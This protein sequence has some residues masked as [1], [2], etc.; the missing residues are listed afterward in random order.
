MKVLLVY[1]N[2]QMVALLPSNIAILAASLKKAGVD[3]RLFDTTLYRIAEKSVDDVRVEHMQ[4]RPFNLKE[5]GVDYKHTDVFEDFERT[6]TEFS[7]DI[8]GISTGDDTFD[9]G[10][11]LVSKV[12][13]PDIHVILGGVYPT[14]SPEEAICNEYV[15]SI[16]IG[17]GEHALVELCLKMQKK[18][19]ITRIRNLWVKHNDVIYK[20]GVRE[21]ADINKLPYE[22]FDVFEEKRFFRPMQGKIFKMI[23]VTIDRGCPYNCSFCAAPL[24]RKLYSDAGQSG[25]FRIKTTAR[26][27]EELQYHVGRYKA[28]YIYFN[29][30]TFFARKEEDIEKFAREYAS[31]IGLPFWCQTRIETITERRIKLLQDMNCDR[32]SIGIEHGNEEFRKTVLNKHFT[33]QQVIRAFKL[34]EKS[35]IPV[36]VNNIIGFPDETRELAF[37]TIRLNRSIKADSVNAYFFVPYRGTSLR[38][39]CIEK[40]YIHADAKTDSLMRRSILN[41]PQFHPNEIEGLVR[42]FPLYVKMPESYFDKIRIAEQL[43]E[44]G[45]RML[46]E[47]RDIYVKE[48][49]R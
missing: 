45:D 28:D 1:P 8:I 4:L 49:F 19:D 32:L 43:N 7:P 5:K 46:A 30:E 15:D 9:L 20:N 23:P 35:R 10:I 42:T 31:E 29:S 39:H 12:K 24:Q 25:Y 33:N 11:A 26:V 22:D 2:L 36:T 44:E 14:F 37:D 18:E 40:G 47:L 16:C 48:Y 38:Q 6:V 41:M 27:I 3:V 34:L 13:R 17:E 21:L